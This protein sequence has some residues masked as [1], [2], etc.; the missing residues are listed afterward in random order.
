MSSTFNKT[1]SRCCLWCY[2]ARS[3]SP[4]WK[5]CRPENSTAA[6]K[7]FGFNESKNSFCCDFLIVGKGAS[8]AVQQSERILQR[9]R[10]NWAQ[11]PD[12]AAAISTE[13]RRLGTP[14]LCV[15][16]GNKRSWWWTLTPLLW[17]RQQWTQTA[18]HSMGWFKNTQTIV[19]DNR[20]RICAWCQSKGKMFANLPN[21]SS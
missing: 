10:L 13:E 14:G 20:N 8:E 1:V 3:H 16:R 6:C 7:V 2:K 4:V 15:W 18:S 12:G 17:L 21:K 5:G 19:R 11:R 9:L